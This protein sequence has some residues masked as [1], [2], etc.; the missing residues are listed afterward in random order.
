MEPSGL[1]QASIGIAFTTG[2]FLKLMVEAL[3]YKKEGR[4]FD[5]Q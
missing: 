1:V 4:G 5:S 2:Y 3:R